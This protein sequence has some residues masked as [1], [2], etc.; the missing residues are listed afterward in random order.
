[1]RSGPIDTLWRCAPAVAVL[2]GPLGKTTP[3]ILL[4]TGT[5]LLV[6]T[7]MQIQVYYTGESR[8]DLILKRN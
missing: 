4:M 2:D 7:Q 3:Q 8:E 5:Y 1:M 6:Y